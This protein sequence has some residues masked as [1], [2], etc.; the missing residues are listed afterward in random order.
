MRGQTQRISRFA[1]GGFDR[2]NFMV[3]G[4][5]RLDVSVRDDEFG[6]RP[7]A[8]SHI[9]LFGDVA[10][11]EPVQLAE[12]D[13]DPAN[14]PCSR[15]NVDLGSGSHHIIV[16]EILNRVSIDRYILLFRLVRD[17]NNARQIDGGFPDGGSDRYTFQL[18]A[19]T[20]FEFGQVD[21]GRGCE[22]DLTI[23]VL[24]EH[25]VNPLPA[26]ALA[27]NGCTTH[28]WAPPAWAI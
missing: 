24:D 21:T 4:P 8:D 25:A 14:P 13:D 11:G 2:F 22:R 26:E 15:L 3:D 27:I 23:E 10:G 9:A 6:C 18:A 1:A 7:S 17:I 12:N 28:P 19:E 5:A 20:P 16:S